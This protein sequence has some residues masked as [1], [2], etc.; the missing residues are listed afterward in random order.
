MC[1]NAWL[2]YQKKLLIFQS[3]KKKKKLDLLNFKPRIADSLLHFQ[4]K[5]KK[6]ERP[7]QSTTPQRP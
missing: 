2:K 5:T 6:K 3:H 1:I 7:S 4:R